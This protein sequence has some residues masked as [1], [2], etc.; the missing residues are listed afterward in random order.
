MRFRFSTNPVVRK[1]E[2]SLVINMLKQEVSSLMEEVKSLRAEVERL[3]IR[4]K[5][6]K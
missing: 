2:L 1:A 6:S 5:Q 3:Q 4:K